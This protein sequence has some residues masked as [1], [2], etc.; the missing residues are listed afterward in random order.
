MSDQRQLGYELRLAEL[1]WRKSL[2]GPLRE[3]GLTIPQYS[4]LRA[5]ER[6]PG[7]SSAELA[8]NA[9]VTPQTMNALVLQL[10]EAELIAR[11][12]SATNLRVLNAELTPAG[13]ALLSKAHRLVGRLESVAVSDLSKAEHHQLLELLARCAAALEQAAPKRG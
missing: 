4:T 7:A 10:E 12:V 5:L 6:A 9:L 13:K 1:A 11:R 2:E 8:R 3:L